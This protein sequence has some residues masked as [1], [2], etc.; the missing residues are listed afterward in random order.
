[1]GDFSGESGSGVCRDANAHLIAHLKFFLNERERVFIRFAFDPNDVG[2]QYRKKYIAFPNRGAKG[3]ML[4]ND[5]SRGGR[6]DVKRWRWLTCLGNFLNLRRCESRHL[7]FL[8]NLLECN[9]G[10]AKDFFHLKQ[11]F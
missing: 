3:H 5:L 7:K 10:A 8:A 6:F 2:V 9:N 11:S 1:M 4:L